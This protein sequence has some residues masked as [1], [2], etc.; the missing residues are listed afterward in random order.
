MLIPKNVYDHI[1]LIII[2]T[3]SL[4]IF[5]SLREMSGLSSVK[6]TFTSFNTFAGDISV[7]PMAKEIRTVQLVSALIA[8]TSSVYYLAWA[9]G[10][11]N[12]PTYTETVLWKVCATTTAG[13]SY[14]LLLHSSRILTLQNKRV[15]FLIDVYV[16]A[17]IL[18]VLGSLLALRRLPLSALN[19]VSW[20]SY[21]PHI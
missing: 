18:I 8:M 19:V 2:H 4:N 15:A 7:K 9:S 16:V 14:A 21:I 11:L 10:V 17:R 3:A 1:S 5:D 6:G 13:A 20:T 12:L